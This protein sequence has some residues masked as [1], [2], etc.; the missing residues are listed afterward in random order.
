[1]GIRLTAWGLLSGRADSKDFFPSRVQ[2]MRLIADL[3]EARIAA[4]APGAPQPSRADLE[5]LVMMSF[6]VTLGYGLGHKAA[7]ASLGKRTS[8]EAD[9]EFRARVVEMFELYL[10]RGASSP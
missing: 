9:A 3:L 1:M 6:V 8:A 10:A 7:R 5:F 4:R 2:G